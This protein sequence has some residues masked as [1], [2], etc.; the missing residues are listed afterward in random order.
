M[1]KNVAED[2]LSQF[3]VEM[4]L[5]TAETAG[6]QSASKSLGPE[7]ASA[8]LEKLPDIEKITQ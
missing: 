3:E 8:E 6:I 4:G 1:E 2:L 7:L 5:K